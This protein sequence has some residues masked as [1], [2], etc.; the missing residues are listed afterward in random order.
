MQKELQTASPVDTPPSEQLTRS[1]RLRARLAVRIGAVAAFV[2]TIVAGTAAPSFAASANLGSFGGVV[3]STVSSGVGQAKG[4]II[5]AFPY[6]MGVV[7]F[8]ALWRIGRKVI[9]K[10]SG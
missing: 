8:F 4:I 1:E 5:A 7:V 2:M 3:N 10:V 9:S 6:V